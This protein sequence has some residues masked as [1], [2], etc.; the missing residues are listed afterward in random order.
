MLRTK[1]QLLYFLLILI[2]NRWIEVQIRT[3]K[4]KK[5]DHLKILT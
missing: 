1:L 3:M 5:R 4:E 2:D